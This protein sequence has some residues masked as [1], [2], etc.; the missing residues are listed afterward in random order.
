MLT[1][2]DAQLSFR[3]L[4]QGGNVNPETLEQAEVM[5]QELRPESPVRHRL[6]GELKE[7][8]RIHGY[9]C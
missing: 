5:L 3:R 1:E 6:S 4:F 7:I 8:K 9:R 2:A